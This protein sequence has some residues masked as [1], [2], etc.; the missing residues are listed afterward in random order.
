MIFKSPPV[1]QEISCVMQGIPEVMFSGTQLESEL[2]KFLLKNEFTILE[3]VRKDF[4]PQGYTLFLPLAESHVAI[5]TYPEYNSIY[6]NMYSCR[7][8]RDAKPTFE[9]VKE[10]FRPKRIL[11]YRE[12]KIPV[13]LSSKNL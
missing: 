5:H 11:F 2:E 12:D 1:G 9:F 3:P 6:F 8:S 13:T 4:C 10:M 7:G